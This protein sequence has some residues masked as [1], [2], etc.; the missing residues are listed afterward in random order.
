MRVTTSNCQDIQYF[1]DICVRG[2]QR[3]QNLACT[4]DSR[5]AKTQLGVG[6]LLPFFPLVAA[7]ANPL[8][9]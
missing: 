2:I 8:R 9:R 3:C 7:H 4:I 6:R 5:S 1:A